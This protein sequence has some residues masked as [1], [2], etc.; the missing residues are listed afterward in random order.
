[1]TGA[2]FNPFYEG[3]ELFRSFLCC[4]PAGRRFYTRRERI[5][6]LEEMKKRL[7]QELA[8]IEE[9]LEDLKKAEAK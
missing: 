7:R 2:S 1:M 3:W 4:G 5:A 9:L 6:Q 8:G